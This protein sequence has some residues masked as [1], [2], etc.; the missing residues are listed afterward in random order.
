VKAR[1]A[2]VAAMAGELRPLV[3]GWK[4]EETP[5]GVTIYTCDEAVA[6]FAGLGSQRARL[7]TAA[8]LRL[9][10]IRRII[11]A[12][13]A[14][15]LHAAMVPGGV[16]HV[17]EIV[18]PVTGEVMET[19]ESDG[20]NGS[21]AVLVTTNVVTTVEDKR[22][23]RKMYSADLV[24]MEASTVAEAAR[25]NKIPFSAIKGISDGYDFDLPGMERFTT[26]DGQF[27]QTSFAVYAALRPTLWRPVAKLA[28]DSGMAAR[29][30]SRELLCYLADERE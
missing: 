7:A 20:L 4:R 22:R 29:N 25:R 9:G 24:D 2:I 27:R 13:W 26:A 16:W 21:G 15:G 8:V 1:I 10:P 14:G 12:G 17:R 30:L 6:A 3:K 5:E 11:S 28:K 23:L 19:S 18:N